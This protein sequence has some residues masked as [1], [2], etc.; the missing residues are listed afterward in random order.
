MTSGSERSALERR[1]SCLIDN[2]GELQLQHLCRAMAWLGEELDDDPSEVRYPLHIKDRIE[3]KAFARCRDL[4]RGL[5]LDSFDTTPLF[6]T[7]E[8]G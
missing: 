6:F 7:G 5:D 4:F 3:E 1:E 8:G 2:A